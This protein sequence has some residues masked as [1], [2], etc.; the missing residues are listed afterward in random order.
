LG[1]D[2]RKQYVTATYHIFLEPSTRPERYNVKTVL[3]VAPVCPDTLP[4]LIPP[5]PKYEIC[6]SDVVSM[7]CIIQNLYDY[8]FKPK[9]RRIALIT[10]PLHLLPYRT[11][12]SATACKQPRNVQQ[13]RS[14]LP[15]NHPALSLRGTRQ[16]KRMSTARVIL[17]LVHAPTL[18]RSKTEFRRIHKRLV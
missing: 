5:H 16:W 12:L 7:I 14:P 15:L 18:R 6:H 2:P 17:K 1:A 9:I 4:W 13:C 11:V 10:I 8:F 3:G